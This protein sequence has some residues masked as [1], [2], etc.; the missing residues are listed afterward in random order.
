[1][2]IASKANIDP[3]QRSKKI[4]WVVTVAGAIM[5][6]L[7]LIIVAG[8]SFHEARST[9]DSPGRLTFGNYTRA[10]TQGHLG[11]AFLNSAVVAITVTLLQAL[12]STMAAYSLARLKF[13]GR[14][15]LLLLFLATLAIPLQLLVV[16][17]F[18]VLKSGH[19]IDTYGALILPTAVN[20]FGIFLLCQYFSTIP[21][22]LEE[23]AMLDGADR[24]QVLWKVIFPLA[25]PAIVA[26]C[27]FS[28]VGE[29]NDVIKPL[30]FTTRPELQTVQLALTNFEEQF[31]NDW[32]LLMAGVT[33]ATIPIVVLFVAAQKQF[34]RGLAATGTKG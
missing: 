34:V 13:R 19:L 6:L 31:T 12:T 26:L 11:W 23:A 16:P 20:G 33:I 10:W 2:L 14:R 8:V 3:A 5:V 28:F 7:P 25:K 24:W 4:A 30:V 22:E 21:I 15:G 27:L 18:M 32:P 1:M 29:W 9:I 17:I